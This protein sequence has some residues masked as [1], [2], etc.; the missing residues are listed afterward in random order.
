[1][2]NIACN[3]L[4]VLPALDVRSYVMTLVMVVLGPLAS[5]EGL[6]DEQ[7]GISTIKLQLLRFVRTIG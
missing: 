5:F 4:H 1:L 7:C 2:P 3:H 6:D